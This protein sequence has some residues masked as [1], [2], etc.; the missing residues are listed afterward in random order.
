MIDELS[1]VRVTDPKGSAD[2]WLDEHPTT[3]APRKAPHIL[4][5]PKYQA[6]R[7]K[8]MEW[9]TQE[10]EIQA[11]NREQM[12][13]DGDFYD[14]IQW[15]DA[16]AEEVE[17][18]GQVASVYNEVAPTCDWIIGTE[19]RTRIDFKVLPRTE[20]DVKRAEAKTQVLKWNSDVNKTPFARSLAFADAV[21]V[22]IG[23]LEDGA[24]GDPTD[25]PLFSRHE[26]WR[27][28]LHDS[29]GVER[30]LSDARYLFR[31][32]WVD[33]DIAEAMFPDR[34]AAVR[35]AA[36]AA[37]LYGNEEDEDFWYL[38]QHYQ[39]RNSSGQVV[40][41]RSYLSDQGMLFNTRPR[42]K[43]IEC[44]YRMPVRC[45]VC[46][47]DSDEFRGKNYNKNNEAMKAAVESGAVS[48]YDKI[49]MRVRCAMMTE[50]DLLQDV[51]SPY[52]HNRFP[53]TP[54]FCYRRGRDGAVYGIIRR[55]RDPQEDFNKRA[56]K[57][58][59]LMSVNRVVADADAVE[60]HEE[61][62]E[63]AARPDAY[64]IKKRGSEFSIENNSQLA[65]GHLML[66]DRD[67]RMIR[68]AGGVTD[69]NLGR[70][71][72][73][74]SGEAIKARQLQGS[75]VTAEIFDN[76]RFSIQCQG[77]LQLSLAEQYITQA[78]VIRLT[79]ARGEIEWL[80]INHP[81]QDAMGNWRFVNDIT[82]S[83]ADFKV[84]EQDYHQSVRQ[85]MFDSMSDL[86]GKIA[87][88]DPKS[89]LRILKMALEFSDLPNKD[90]MAN[91]IAEM[92]GLQKKRDP[93]DMTPEQLQDS[94]AEELAKKQ[95]QALQ[96]RQV[97]LAMAE[98]EAKVNKTNAEAERLMADAE[99]LRAQALQMGGDGAADAAMRLEY[100]QKARDIEEKAAEAVND[101]RQEIE[102]LQAEAAD[103]RHEID[104][105][106][107]TERDVAK[108]V[109]DGKVE[110]ARL[111]AK[112]D[113][114]VGGL[115]E[116]IKAL[117]TELKTLTAAVGKAE[118]G[119]EH[120]KNSPKRKTVAKK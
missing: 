114:V 92:L 41:N 93:E 42:V 115:E 80:R 107:V 105:K 96:Q 9:Y 77:E 38:G 81:E 28:M 82:A 12:A 117:A 58:L 52:K 5:S 8:L 78:K 103:R 35:R 34:L 62:R 22:G 67:S 37:N 106:A 1:N 27:Y 61:A 60:D 48:L 30:D 26:N 11:A 65:E 91:E 10:R 50:G 14:N 112:V 83:Q 75:V 19:K 88:V 69:D 85:A 95:A 18:R 56:S 47:G 119:I 100:D 40:S 51:P 25:E 94:K 45:Q 23:W 46:H 53:F 6:R 97:E 101:A 20:D 99:R 108:I 44:W 102:R 90:D 36:V 33:L 98:Q 54:I 68:Q 84:D 31:I 64:I 3:D 73:A 21:K 15:K 4:D 13:I 63:E 86:V 55:I 71:T 43:L 89:A 29:K 66:M 32:K 49:E 2:R 39:A 104:T 87:A 70:Q 113:N 74:V 110:E 17:E 59:F 116:Q 16:D 7:R 24:R 76:L 118:K 109:A 57:A 111:A 79:Q 72:N 120:L